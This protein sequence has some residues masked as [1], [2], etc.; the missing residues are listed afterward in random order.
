MTTIVI[1]II[2]V[3]FIVG[4]QQAY[5]QIDEVDVGFE[6][7]WKT[8]AE[9]TIATAE[10]SVPRLNCSW[11][12]QVPEGATIIEDAKG[13]IEIVIGEEVKTETEISDEATVTKKPVIKTEQQIKIEGI[14]TAREQIESY[15]KGTKTLQ[16]LCFGGTEREARIFEQY[17]TIDVKRPNDN[18]PLK[19]DPQYRYE[20]ILS[21]ICKAEYVKEF[22]IKNPLRTYPGEGQQEKFVA[23]S[24]FEGLLWD[25]L[26]GLDNPTYAFAERHMTEFNFKKSAQFAEA[27]KCSA[28][29]KSMGFCRDP[30]TGLA[31]PEDVVTKSVAGKEILSKFRAYQETGVTEIPKQKPGEV[32]DPTVSLDQYI[33]AYGITEEQL[34]EW[35]EGRQ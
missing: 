35:F 14:I 29:G 32:F 2:A 5:A 26:E 23:R 24:S 16:E 1:P 19:T 31:P 15:W 11:L 12:G 20:M 7:G 28:I 9:S 3:L 25:E 33:K 4:I 6:W 8:C 22:K 18:K 17:A 30:F 13:N 27:F 10:G 21:E 34:K